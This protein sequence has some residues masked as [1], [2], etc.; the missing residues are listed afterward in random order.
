MATLDELAASPER[1]RDLSSVEAADLL[2]RVVG[3]QTVL[4]AR[5]LAGQTNGPA[6]DTPAEDR[7][8]SPEEAARRLG[9]TLRWLYRHAKHLPFTRRLSRKA[10]RFSA[11]GLEK[12]LRQ[13]QGR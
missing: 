1:V 8:L 12:Y 7:L 2:L 6:P 9:V 10:L 5:A 13:R 4:L 3:L 11:E